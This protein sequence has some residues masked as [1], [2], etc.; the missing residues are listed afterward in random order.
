MPLKL[1]IISSRKIG[2]PDYGSRGA[3]VGLELEVDPSLL[4]R[5]R[6]LHEKIVNLFRLAKRSVDGELTG[7]QPTEHHQQR[8]KID[9]AESIR[10][11]TARQIRA[12]HAIA[13]RRKID[14]CAELQSRA[15][16]ARL[17]E[18]SLDEAS[19]LITTLGASKSPLAAR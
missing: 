4:D 7:G 1:S 8:R 13:K 6:H 14:L 5:P 10:S 11:A 3:A 16:V 19:E 17:E 15:G 12:L 2:Q 9:S 18:L